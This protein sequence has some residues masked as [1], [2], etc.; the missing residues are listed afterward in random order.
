MK[1]PKICLSLF[2]SSD[3][4]CEAIN[5]HDADLFEIRLDLSSD[6]NGPQIR[7]ATHKPLLFTA[8]A[9]PDL[10]E[11]FWPF[12]DYVDVEQEEASG[13]NTI[14]SIHSTDQDPNVLWES[15]SGEHIT[16]IVLETENY[17][18][19]SQLIQ[20]NALHAPR[21]IC[22][23]SGETGA[24]S[25]IV[26]ALYGARWLY[27]PLADRTTGNGQFTFDDLHRTYQVR[28][29]DPLQKISVFGIV[30]NPV[31]HSRSPEIQNQKFAE[32]SLPW[33]Y[34]PF[35]TSNLS[36]LIE[37]AADWRTKGFSITHPYKEEIIKMLDSASP[38]VQTLRSCNTVAYVD[39]K[40]HG[41]NT[42]VEGIRAL[43]KDI[44]LEQKRVVILGAGA[45]SRAIAMV[46]RER[47]ADVIVLNRTQEKADGSLDD[48]AKTDY[49]VLINATPV[50]WNSGEC[51]IDSESLQPGK[52]V[53]DAIYQDTEL[54]K[55]A[56]SIGCSTRN[57][58]I[59]FQ[60]QAEAQYQFWRK[61]FLS[62]P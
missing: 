31:S 55:R 21:G 48:F 51:P 52:I 40:W 9:R 36:G 39:G 20:L 35:P 24:F 12:A 37:N 46:T 49:D 13:Q 6:L 62:N 32:N 61:T 56:R 3:E 34:L 26:S 18:T 7:A 1:S 33:I 17:K 28:R 57:G 41:I 50:G 2:G 38:D 60:T 29:F 19:I 14:R 30:G 16:K 4:I 11:Q 43:L 54:L 23:A 25:R 47:S 59:W 27:A 22:F 5:S 58:E 10:L 53:I 45:S 15:F 42:D 8:H 44:S